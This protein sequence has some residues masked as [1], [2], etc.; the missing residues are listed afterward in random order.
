MSRRVRSLCRLGLAPGILILTAM[1]VRVT[2]VSQAA[3]AGRLTG[4]W[5]FNSNQ[6]DNADE[7][8]QQ[9][10]QNSRVGQT[11]GGGG[12]GYPGGGYPGSGGMGV[13]MGRGGIGIGGIGRGGMGRRASGPSQA[14]GLS[15]ADLEN[16]AKDSK[17]LTIR[18]DDEKI[19]VV[20]DAGDFKDLYPDDK[21][22]KEKDASGQTTELKTHWDG[23]R[24]LVESKLKHAG[25]LTETY[26]ISPD[27]KQLY[28][29]EQLD[30]SSLPAPL[31]IRRVYDKAGANAQ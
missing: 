21:K 9:A 4:T 11:R 24:L 12:G 27:G 31:I 15:G 6:S 25:K 19:S 2:P 28:V 20:N 16:I 17:R 26:E 10:E 29:T 7:K 13:P 1:V 5:N 23:Q 3:D 30:N 18:R 8:I 14:K 22:H